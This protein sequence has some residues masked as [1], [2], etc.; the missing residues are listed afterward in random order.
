MR[1]IAA[2][3]PRRIDVGEVGG[4]IFVNCALLGAYPSIVRRRD[5]IQERRGI[6][7]WTAFVVA[8]VGVL[9][10]YRGLAV[11]VR[12]RD[13]DER[14]TT[15]PFVIIACHGYQLVRLA[16]GLEPNIGSGT[17]RVG[18]AH[19]RGRPSLLRL[20]LRAFF[21]HLRRD[22]DYDMLESRELWAVPDR[23]R[24][25]SVAVDGELVRLDVPLHFRTLA[26]ALA[27]IVPEE[28]AGTAGLPNTTLGARD[29]LWETAHAR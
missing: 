5:E 15:T 28:R 23:R 18:V 20:V 6:R 26:G 22:R 12:T 10:R 13:G 21:G 4:R 27:V 7:E 29:G 9:R 19:A 17:L 14:C 16:L 25:V 8:A 24:V 2:G 1:A 11:R 3:V